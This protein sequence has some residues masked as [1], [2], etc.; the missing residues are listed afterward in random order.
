MDLFCYL[1]SE[2]T[3]PRRLC[4]VLIDLDSRNIDSRL[5]ISLGFVWWRFRAGSLSIWDSDSSWLSQHDL[6]CVIMKRD[7]STNNSCVIS[8]N[9]TF[10]CI[11]KKEKKILLLILFLI[12]N[13][14]HWEIVGIIPSW[15]IKKYELHSFCWPLYAEA[16]F[17]LILAI[18]ICREDVSHIM[19]KYEL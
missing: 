8:G 11:F 17:E 5:A 14:R 15:V 4:W 1:Y 9:F 2:K 16:R 12:N 6:V 19:F 13:N 7:N 3:M 18:G 10:S